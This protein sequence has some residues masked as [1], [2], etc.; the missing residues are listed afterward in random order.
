MFTEYIN[1]QIVY[2]N[3]FIGDY[4]NSG[5]IAYKDQDGYYWFIGRNDDVINTAGHLV[6]PFEVESVLMELPKLIDV[7]VVGI[8][9]PILFE[10]VIAFAVL[11]HPENNLKALV[12]EIKLHVT[13]KV[14][15]I[16][17]PKE[18]V[19]VA[20]IPKTKSGKIMRRVLKKQYLHEDIG[21]LSTME[22]D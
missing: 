13:K 17:S 22:E 5:D 21:D 6:S 2:Q 4:Y 8:P 14:S 19:F 18:V 10:K 12:M 7:A 11:R 1:N 16:A 20:K 15:S 9:D 3:K